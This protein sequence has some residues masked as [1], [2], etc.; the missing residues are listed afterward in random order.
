ME[1]APE[2]ASILQSA[3]RM[4]RKGVVPRTRFRL[5]KDEIGFLILNCRSAR[6]AEKQPQITENEEKAMKNFEKYTKQYFL[7]PV[8]CMD[9][10][11]KDSVGKSPVFCMLVLR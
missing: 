10:A 6:R 5:L 3:R 2:K 9:W 1:Y 8:R 4:A 11:E 7:P